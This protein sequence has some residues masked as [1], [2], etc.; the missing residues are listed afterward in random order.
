MTGLGLQSRI[1]RSHA[2]E[3]FR[4][5]RVWPTLVVVWAVVAITF[6]LIPNDITSILMRLVAL[7]AI[8]LMVWS[9]RR[10]KASDQD[11]RKSPLNPPR[12]RR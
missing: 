5:S 1:R 4:S 7:L 11:R 6:A 9:K 2:W 10:M 3:Q 8:S 12:G